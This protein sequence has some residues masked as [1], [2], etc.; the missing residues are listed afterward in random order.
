MAERVYFFW[1]YHITDEDIREILRS[2]N[3]TEKVWAISR[4]LQS[5]RWE[6]IWKY[7]TLNDVRQYFDRIQF[8]SPYLR[9]LW[10]HALAIWSQADE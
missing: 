10:A 3:E 6:D 1:D 4:I 5:A 7:L 2:D 9:D 8:R